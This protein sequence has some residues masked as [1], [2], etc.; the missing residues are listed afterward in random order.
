MSL[1]NKRLERLLAEEGL[2]MDFDEDSEESSSEQ[3]MAHTSAGDVFLTGRAINSE[4]N[5]R[6]LSP[7]DR[8]KFDASMAKE[9]D[10]WQRFNA[11]EI[12][13]KEQIAKHP[14]GC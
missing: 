5:L 9:W 13:S 11:V 7:E 6:D 12:L 14:R 3:Y 10:S 4:V 2:P 8:Q 1:K